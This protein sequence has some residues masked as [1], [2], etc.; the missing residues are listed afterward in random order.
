M[1]RLLWDNDSGLEVSKPP[2]DFPQHTISPPRIVRLV[3]QF[4]RQ[5]E[6]TE[7]PR[8]HFAEPPSTWI[9]IR[10][11]DVV[12]QR[13]ANL[14]AGRGGPNRRSEVFLVDAG[15]RVAT[16]VRWEGLQLRLELAPQRPREELQ[17][18]QVISGKQLAS[19][20]LLPAEVTRVAEGVL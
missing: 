3:R 11:A 10:L 7:L 5:F 9:S 15:R 4:R 6:G 18:R 12:T 17:R 8:D 20:D 14:I 2:H 13:L 1:W 16:P 19:F